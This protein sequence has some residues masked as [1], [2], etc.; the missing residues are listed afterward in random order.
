M[1]CR[2][3][4]LC[5]VS[6]VSDPTYRKCACVLADG[7]SLPWSAKDTADVEHLFDRSTRIRD[8]LKLPLPIDNRPIPRTDISTDD[9]DSSCSSVYPTFHGAFNGSEGCADLT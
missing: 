3:S 2:V 7:V 4:S 9:F 8:T 1:S 5:S 6:P